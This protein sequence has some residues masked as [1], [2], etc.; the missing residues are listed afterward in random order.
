VASRSLQKGEQ[1][2]GKRRLLGG[3]E[4]HERAEGA[5]NF[6]GPLPTCLFGL[7]GQLAGDGAGQVPRPAVRSIALGTPRS[8]L[9]RTQSGTAIVTRM[10]R[11]WESAALLVRASPER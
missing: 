7:T 5:A 4:L 9:R 3:L 6:L 2:L 1:A 10:T 8:T 11:S